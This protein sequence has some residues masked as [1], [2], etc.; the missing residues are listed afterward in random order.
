MHPC[1]KA[2][3]GTRLY[4]Q[5]TPESIRSEFDEFDI[6]AHAIFIDFERQ[7]GGLVFKGRNNNWYFRL[8]PAENF[9]KEGILFVEFVEPCVAQP[10]FYFL[11]QNGEIYAAMNQEAWEIAASLSE[12]LEEYI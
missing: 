4:Q 3:H 7:Y 9:T 5:K 2:K 8:T 10:Y 6:E 12:F 1:V 11:G